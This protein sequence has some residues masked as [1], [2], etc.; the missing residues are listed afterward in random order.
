LPITVSRNYAFT[1]DLAIM[2]ADADW[3]AVEGV[4]SNDMANIGEYIGQ[5]QEVK[6]QQYKHGVNNLLF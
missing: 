5:E 1:D 6:A 4:L 3:Q 2:H